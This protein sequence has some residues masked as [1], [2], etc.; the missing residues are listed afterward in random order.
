MSVQDFE[1]SKMTPKIEEKP[2]SSI[3]L[4]WSQPKASSNATGNVGTLQLPP[5]FKLKGEENYEQ[6][7]NNM[8]NIALANN[9]EDFM[10]AEVEEPQCVYQ[11]NIFEQGGILNQ[12]AVARWRC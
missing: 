2:T 6:W 8:E 4:V 9:L 1:S 12:K 10:C 5:Y 7:K 3:T 11:G